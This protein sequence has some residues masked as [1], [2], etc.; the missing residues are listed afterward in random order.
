MIIHAPCRPRVLRINSCMHII[1]Y[2]VHIIIFYCHLDANI[3]IIICKGV[4]L[5]ACRHKQEAIL[6]ISLDNIIIKGT[7][8]SRVQ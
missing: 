7:F 6:A 2:I 8:Y 3:N 4:K 5:H 1:I